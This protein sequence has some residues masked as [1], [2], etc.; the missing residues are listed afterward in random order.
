MIKNELNAI[1][2]AVCGVAH[3]VK[4]ITKNHKD[5]H[6]TISKVGKVIDK[7]CNFKELR[8]I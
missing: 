3:V 1:Q 8:I 7:V 6:S 4:K 5:E 2:N